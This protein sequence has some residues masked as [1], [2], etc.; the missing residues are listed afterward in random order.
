MTS[1]LKKEGAGVKLVSPNT[2]KEMKMLSST[3]PRRRI[4]AA[5]PHL[6]PDREGEKFAASRWLPTPR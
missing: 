2:K 5:A 3:L 4:G 1:S 6:L